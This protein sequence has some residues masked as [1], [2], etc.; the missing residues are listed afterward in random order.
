MV[1]SLLAVGTSPAV[2]DEEKADHKAA[3]SACCGPHEEAHGCSDAFD[4]S[5]FSDAIS[6]V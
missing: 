6:C 2:A 4:M 5:E 3:T 1:A